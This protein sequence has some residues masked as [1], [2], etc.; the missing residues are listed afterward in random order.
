MVTHPD[1]SFTIAVDNGERA[2]RRAALLGPHFA[3]LDDRARP[4]TRG[5][6]VAFCR[7]V[8][9]RLLAAGAVLRHGARLRPATGR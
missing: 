9:S 5:E 7:R 2:A 6:A 1:V 3:E 8:A 4:A